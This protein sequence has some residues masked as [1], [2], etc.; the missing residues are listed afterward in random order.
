MGGKTGT[1]WELDWRIEMAESMVTNASA[2]TLGRE[3]GWKSIRKSGVGH[4]PDQCSPALI[5][6]HRKV[7][8]SFLYLR[9]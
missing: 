3:G 5:R 2:C 6:N 1:V 7:A 9:E 4:L 8:H